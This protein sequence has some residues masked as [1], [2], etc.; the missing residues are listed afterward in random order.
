MKP[1]FNDAPKKDYEIYDKSLGN[2]INKATKDVV[3]NEMITNELFDDTLEK[4][5]DFFQDHL[6]SLDFKQK[7]LIILL[8]ESIRLMREKLR[9]R[10]EIKR[11]VNV[12]LIKAKELPT[13]EKWRLGTIHEPKDTVEITGKAFA[14]GYEIDYKNL[15]I[16]K[17]NK[18]LTKN[19]NELAEKHFAYWLM[20][21][22]EFKKISLENRTN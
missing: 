14:E 21:V 6:R 9:I 15:Q 5:I 20:I 3:S 22:D 2:Q 11:L 8:D 18:Q 4:K 17:I 13:E 19:F 1:R 10:K 16:E 7:D 12:K